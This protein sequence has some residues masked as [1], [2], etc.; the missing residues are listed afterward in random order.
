LPPQQVGAT[1][2]HAQHEHWQSVRAADLDPVQSLDPVGGVIQTVP[3]SAAAKKA[4]GLSYRP[5]LLIVSTEGISEDM[6]R[7]TKTTLE[8]V[9]RPF[10]LL[11]E[12]RLR[13]A[14]KSR[15]A[16][17]VSANGMSHLS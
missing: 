15:V 7:L 2:D 3:Y 10:D 17:R 13:K 5:D 9:P 6:H 11:P 12:Q 4:R 8:I 16:T 1:H 14:W